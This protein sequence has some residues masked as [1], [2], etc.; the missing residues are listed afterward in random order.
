[1]T[2]SITCTTIRFPAAFI[3][4]R[5]P[6]RPLSVPS[7]SSQSFYGAEGRILPGHKFY[8]V[9]KLDAPGE[10]EARKEIF[11]KGYKTT[12][13]C[14]ISSLKDAHSAVPDMGIPLLTLGV[15]TVVDWNLSTPTTLMFE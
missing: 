14:T 8:L 12:V 2:S 4:P 13:K 6:G 3:L 1:M 11:T 9:G 7:R 15:D 5:L 10:G